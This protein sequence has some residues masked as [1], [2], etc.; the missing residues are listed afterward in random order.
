MLTSSA[1]DFKEKKYCVLLAVLLKRLTSLYLKDNVSFSLCVHKRGSKDQQQGQSRR[2]EASSQQPW[3][4]PSLV[5][6]SRPPTSGQ[7]PANVSPGE[8]AG[9]IVFLKDKRFCSFDSL[10]CFSSV[11]VFFVCFLF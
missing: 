11:A 8:A 7:I 3:Y 5:S 1:A 6:S 2:Q 4:S 9:I 10:L